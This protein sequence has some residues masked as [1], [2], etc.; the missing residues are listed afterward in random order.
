MK[1]PIGRT[2]IEVTRGLT[3]RINLKINLKTV[4]EDNCSEM[5][6][7]FCTPTRPTSRD[8]GTHDLERWRWTDEP[9]PP[10]KEAVDR[11]H[12]SRCHRV[13]TEYNL[14]VERSET[15]STYEDV[16][17]WKTR[18]S[19]C[20]EILL[21]SACGERVKPVTSRGRGC[22]VCEQVSRT[23]WTSSG[24]DMGVHGHGLTSPSLE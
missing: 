16:A 8:A 15:Q 7:A 12:F 11:E 6:A 18:Q 23:A 19:W 3:W 21:Q 10:G 13:N 9:P 14:R 24:K 5:S 2:L 1:E 22:Y 4:L 20:P 17:V